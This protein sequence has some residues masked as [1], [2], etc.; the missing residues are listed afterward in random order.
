VTT[1]FA[2]GRR[3]LP[4]VIAS[5]L[6]AHDGE[7]CPNLIAFGRKGRVKTTEGF[8]LVALGGVHSDGQ[9]DEPMDAYAATYTDKDASAAKGYND[10]DILVTSEWPSRIRYL[11]NAARDVKP[12]VQ[13]QAVADLCTAL[14]PR[15]HFS[16]GQTFF[17]REPFFHMTEAPRPITKFVSIAPFG[18]KDQQK[19]L[20]AVKME[21]TASPPTDMPDGTTMS[22]F[23][24]GG[25]QGTKRKLESQQDSYNR[26]SGDQQDGSQYGRGGK[27]GHRAPRSP[28]KPASCYFCLGNQRGE[29]HMV[30]PIGSE[31][32]LTVSKGPLPLRTTFPGLTFPGHVLIILV[33]HAPTLASE[34]LT[35]RLSVTEEMY[36]YRDALQRMLAAQSR[37][38]SG[39][40]KLG[41]VTWEI[42]RASGVHLQWQLMPFDAEKIQQGLI[43]AAFEAEAEN[44]NYPTKFAFSDADSHKP[45]EHDYF[46]VHMWS[47]GA[48]GG[49]PVT[50]TLPLNGSFRFDL[51][52]GRRV[53]A[54]LLGLE[55]RTHWKGCPQPHDEEAADAQVLNA[56]FEPFNPEVKFELNPGAKGTPPQG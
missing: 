21:H 26:Y 2:I 19:W 5:H 1:Y 7:L 3:A 14:K 17:Q 25:A 50:M 42:S 43:G 16:A 4:P 41:A 9:G 37:D 44:L 46:K 6:N 32:Y 27:R 30:G 13:S 29:E 22:P 38:E 23:T 49:K 18:N 10:A 47:E 20:Y 24:Q 53:M 12:S 54:K 52:F 39:R 8:K 45:V 28:P 36:R 55:H 33:Q 31:V 48:N 11:S 51:Q 40:A 34:E 56:M 35:T 15:Y